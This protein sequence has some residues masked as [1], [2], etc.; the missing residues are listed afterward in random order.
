MRNKIILMGF[1]LCFLAMD[2]IAFGDNI[3]KDTIPKNSVDTLI[4]RV[5]S[6]PLRVRDFI[7]INS[8]TLSIGY[9]KPSMAYFNNTFLPLANTPNRFAG[10]P[11]VG[12]N[13]S[14]DF[15]FNFGTR[16]GIWYWGD[17]VKGQTG[18]SFQKLNVSLS[19]F[20]LGAFYTYKAGYKG[21]IPYLGI[22]ESFLLVQNKYD[23]NDMVI[24]KGGNDIAFMP[25]IGIN[26]SVSEKIVI[27]LEYGYCL[28]WYLQDVELGTG[29]IA[30]H[31][32]IN[33]SKIQFTIGY[34]I[35]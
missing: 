3:P 1:V 6:T 15:P 23:A 13:V 19:G 35:P 32:K 17:N 31:V 24:K 2:L 20:S 11:I 14:F 25:F 21:I 7:S 16:L 26:R 8:A 4:N 29:S 5:G 22:E 34:K 9:Y 10:N 30:E 18:S 27:G 33:G 12:A 28:G